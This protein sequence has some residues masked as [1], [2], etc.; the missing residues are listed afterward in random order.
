MKRYGV[1]PETFDIDRDKIDVFE[2]DRR[3]WESMWYYPRGGGP[4][5]YPNEKMK[6][7]LVSPKP[8]IPWAKD[9]AAVA[10]P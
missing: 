7:L 10:S 8:D 3:Y 6:K 4:K 5:L 2:T 9:L 1:L